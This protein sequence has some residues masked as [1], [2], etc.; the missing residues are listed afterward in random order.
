MN[1]SS[2]IESELRQKLGINID[3][4]EINKTIKPPDQELEI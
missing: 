4:I 1:T 3:K 2:L